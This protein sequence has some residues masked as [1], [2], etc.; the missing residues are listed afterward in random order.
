[1]VSKNLR[2]KEV[3]FDWNVTHHSG[4]FEIGSRFRAGCAVG[5]VLVVVWAG[6]QRTTMRGSWGA[7]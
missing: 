7:T 5:G 4:G 6:S 3:G 1:M 2:G